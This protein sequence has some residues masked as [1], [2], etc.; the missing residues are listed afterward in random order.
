MPVKI[1]INALGLEKIIINIVI[2]YYSFLNLIIM[3]KSFLFILNFGLLLCYFFNI[4]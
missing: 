1:N 2:W 4:L 3:D